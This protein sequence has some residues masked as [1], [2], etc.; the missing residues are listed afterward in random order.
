M[1]SNSCSIRYYSF[2]FNEYC[3]DN[4]CCICLLNA[5]RHDYYSH[6]RYVNHILKKKTVS[7]SLVFYCMHFLWSILSWFSCST[8]L[9]W[10][11]GIN[12]RIRSSDIGDRLI[13]CW[14]SFYCWREASWRLLFRSI[15]SC[16]I[17]RYVGYYLLCYLIADLLT[18]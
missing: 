16:W 18:N 15:K 8:I 5:E 14:R 11:R 6:S 7:S 2:N 1:A 17:R 3:L 4:G 10:R 12:K 13:L 9:K